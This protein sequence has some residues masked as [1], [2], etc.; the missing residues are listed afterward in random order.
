[1]RARPVVD[2]AQPEGRRIAVVGPSGS[3]KTTLLLRWSGLLDGE[4]R[5]GAAYVAEDAHLF[6]TTVLENLRVADGALTEPAA[7]AALRAVGLADWLAELPDGL[8]TRLTAGANSV[9]GGQRRRLLLARA[10]LTPA[11]TLLLDEPTEHLDSADAGTLLHALLTPDDLI[12]AS[13]TVVVATH[14]LA[15]VPAGTV[16]VRVGAQDTV[17]V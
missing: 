10:L 3:G 5:S 2:I 13:R 9:S 7:C 11:P 1:V 12:P 17:P 15:D 8:H 14:H 4:L 16:V 6:D